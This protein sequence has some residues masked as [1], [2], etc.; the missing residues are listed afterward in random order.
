[1]VR[2]SFILVLVLVL[3]VAVSAQ[4]PTGDVDVYGGWNFGKGHKENVALNL[5]FDSTLYYVH[6]GVSGG[7]NYNPTLELTSI[8]NENA[9]DQNM[10]LKSDT[11]QIQ[12][13]KWNFRAYI[14]FGF[15]LTSRDLL[16]V[17]AQY[18]YDDTYKTE[19]L[20]S[21]R[22]MTEV[23]QNQ[24]YR[25]DTLFGWQNDQTV[26]NHHDLKA[27]LGYKHRFSPTNMLSLSLKMHQALGNDGKKREL[28][29][30]MFANSRNY[31]DNNYLEEGDYRLQLH[32]DDKRLGGVDHLRML[33]GVDLLFDNDVDRYRADYNEPGRRDTTILNFHRDYLSQ[34]TE[35]FIHL[36]YSIKGWEFAIKERPQIYSNLQWERHDVV[37]PLL[38]NRHTQFANL[39]EVNIAYLLRARH[40]FELSYSYNVVRPDYKQFST[41]MRL[42]NSEGEFI[43][44]NDSLRPEKRQKVNFSYTYKKDQHLQTRLDVFYG[45]KKDKIEKVVVVNKTM[46]KEIQT[47]KTYTNADIQHSVGTNLRLKLNYEALDAETWAGLTW[48]RFT[49]YSGKKP[50][51]E[52]S[53]QLGLMLNAHLNKYVDMQ[54]SLVYVSPTRS[55]FTEKNEYIDANL[56]LTYKSPVGVNLFVEAKDIINKPRTEITWNESMTYMKIKEKVENRNCL[57]VGISYNW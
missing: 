54:S 32:Y 31:T 10:S 57:G 20:N 16:T 55:A 8:L 44:G 40:R 17:D 45:H 47:L 42:S 3:S 56:R 34:Y 29:G 2:K 52:V 1:M 41:V 15:H 22:Y 26:T 49:Y 23:I 9:K 50:K 7:H 4:K 48:E 18:E 25:V 27:A 19:N 46:N 6:V 39:A 53:Y 5:K 11:N 30:N 38:L 37:A 33:A 43:Q 13:R 28:T 12:T 35:P 14:D 36:Q 21:T 24:T 51:D